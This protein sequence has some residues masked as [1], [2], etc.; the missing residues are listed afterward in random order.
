LENISE[1]GAKLV[2]TPPPKEGISGMLGI[3][4]QE[5]FCTVI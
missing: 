1:E 3:N 5:Y 2:I 4:G